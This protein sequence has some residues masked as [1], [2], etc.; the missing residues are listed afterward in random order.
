MPME[1]Y[2]IQ[3]GNCYL[4]RW[5]AIHEVKSIEK[6]EQVTVISYMQ[7]DGGGRS[8][9]QQTLSM[10]KFIQDLQEQVKCPDSKSW[11]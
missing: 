2:S 3:A 6:E 7:T 8:T 11:G 10:S 9:Q 5:G 4:D 1:R